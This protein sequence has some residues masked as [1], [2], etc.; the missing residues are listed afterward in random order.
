[1][2]LGLVL[3]LAGCG[4]SPRSANLNQTQVTQALQGSPPALGSLH[5]QAG[6]LLSGGT[7]A[8][9]A[10]L[11]SLKGHPVVVNKWA[12]WCGPCR[13]EF[14]SF[15]RAAVS[16]GSRVAFVGVDGTDDSGKAAAF[17]REFRVTYPSYVDPHES[18][19]ASLE[20]VGSYPQ[21]VFID[22]RGKVVF[23]H[24]GQYRDL[25]ALERD[26]RRY[27]LR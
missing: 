6:Q 7:G 13:F 9:K 2:I 17:L 11:A 5:A 25:A 19:A 20:A 15:Q 8:F 23:N 14:P 4:S 18:I 26:I 27:A 21:T 22:R 24:Q 16:Y 3:V 1:M 10:R 12:S